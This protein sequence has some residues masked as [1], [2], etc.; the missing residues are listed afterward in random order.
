MLECEEYFFAKEALRGGRTQTHQ[1][2]VIPREY[3][4]LVSI[5]VCSQYPGVQI[6]CDF[7]IGV[8]T[9]HIIAPEVFPCSYH[10][11]D[12]L[13]TCACSPKLRRSKINKKLCIVEGDF[14][15]QG[16]F[17]FGV[18]DVRFPDRQYHPT[19]PR[20]DN[21]KKKCLFSLEPMVKQCLFSEELKRAIERGATVTKCWVFHEYKRA[22]S[23]WGEFTKNTFKL[24][25]TTSKP[26]SEE[27]CKRYWDEHQL[28]V[29]PEDCV[30]NGAKRM[31]AKILCNSAWG[32]NAENPD[33]PDTRHFSDAQMHEYCEFVDRHNKEQI[34][35]G[36][37]Y[38]LHDKLLSAKYTQVY[39]G[40]NRPDLSKTFI[41]AAVCVPA[42]EIGRA[43][44]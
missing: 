17:G 18:F 27:A 2:E 23:L 29:K 24:K 13:G 8:P 33:K 42:Y 6:N 32:K 20:F 44:V 43:H 16:K 3:E 25:L 1:L 28:A 9:I 10:Y 14:V 15:W 37:Q 12:I 39:L 31:I 19:L 34:N 35:I 11:Q 41:A 22:P 40:R 5:D 36:N 26:P 4:K 38:M 30:F 7:P 21:Q